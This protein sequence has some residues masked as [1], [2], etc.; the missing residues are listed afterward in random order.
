[1]RELGYRVRRR[2]AELDPEGDHEELA[3]LSHQVLH[4]DP[5]PVHAAYLVGFARQMAVPSIAR[6]MYRGGGGDMVADSARR[7][8]D[9][10]TF[11][12]EFLRRGHSTPEGRTAIARMERIHARF[13]ITDEQK[14]YTLATV[15]F[16]GDRLAERLGHDPFT[17]AERLAHWHFWRGVAEQMPLG[18]L[19]AAREELWRW[20]LDYERA[21]WAYTEGGRTIVDTLFED[22]AT[23]WFP[24]PARRA[25]RQ[26]LLALMDDRLRAVHRLE[27][28]S[29]R[30]QRALRV[31][32]RAWDRVTP[33][34]PL[35]RERSWAEHFGRGHGRPPDLER[36]G[37]ESPGAPA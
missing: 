6:V 7:T 15:I 4:G 12:G 1:M 16:E 32:S 18:G 9:T 30:A 2:I 20:M 37:H 11:F 35:R 25:A 14:R 22:W 28:P 36:V 33:L 34:R 17:P 26:V 29:R 27:D 10:L 5:I 19:P 8:D 21:H 23:R 13:P 24:R 3:R 31:G